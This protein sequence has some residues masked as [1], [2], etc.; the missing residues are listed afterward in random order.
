MNVAAAAMSPSEKAPRT[1]SKGYNIILDDLVYSDKDTSSSSSSKTLTNKNDLKY[2]NNN[3]NNNNKRIKCYC[4][5]N[6]LCPK[7]SESLIDPLILQQQQ[8][9]QQELTGKREAFEIDNDFLLNLNAHLSVDIDKLV[10]Q[11][12]NNLRHCVTSTVCVTKRIVRSNGQH[13]NKYYCDQSA[14]DSIRGKV[15]EYRDCKINTPHEADRLHVEKTSSEYCC[16]EREYCNVNL[17]P[18]VA[19]KDLADLSS[20]PGSNNNNINKGRI[21]FLL[22]C[23]NTTRQFSRHTQNSFFF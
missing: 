4:N 20:Y 7:E 12:N 13:W 23:C 10:N 22:V 8:Q 2:E 16:N 6:S 11:T 18:V 14:A 9:Q 3:N 5:D 15:L 17:H 21:F 1:N 19:S